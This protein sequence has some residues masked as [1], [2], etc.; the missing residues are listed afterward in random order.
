MIYN[1]LNGRDIPLSDDSIECRKT[2][3]ERKLYSLKYYSK[4]GSLFLDLPKHRHC[5]R[6]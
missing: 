1:V 5:N 6:M 4:H 2:E 3:F